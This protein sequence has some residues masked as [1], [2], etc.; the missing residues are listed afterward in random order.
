M[1]HAF[2]ST[3]VVPGGSLP[4]TASPGLLHL[5][6]QA[7]AF[8]QGLDP[9][10]PAVAQRLRDLALRL[11]EDRFHL[12]VLGQ[13]KRGKSTL[14]NALLGEPLLPSAVVPLTSIPTFIHAGV[15]LE[16]KIS[17]QDENRAETYACDRAE[18]MSNYLAR[19]VAEE[20]NPKNHLG[21]S[22]VE[23]FHPAPILQRGVVLIDT[24]GIGSTFR[25]NTE[26]TLNFLPQCDA[27]LFVVSADPPVT[28]VE[29]EFLGQVRDKVARLFF[30]LNKVD[31]LSLEER[32]Q[33]ADF[34]KR[35]LREQLG[36][37][38]DVILFCVSARQGLEAAGRE[39]STLWRQSG[40][41]ELND[42]LLDFLVEG[43]SSALNEAVARKAAD[44]VGEVAMRVDL[45]LRALEMPLTELAERR[46][47]FEEKLA[48][49]RDQ[50]QMAGDLLA[51]D[52]KRMQQFLESKAAE[53]RQRAT[54][55]L[56]QVV[57]D[58]LSKTMAGDFHQ[59]AQDALDNQV[60][61]FFERELG[62]LIRDVDQRLTQVLRPH[63]ARAT[64]LIASVRKTAAE[65]FEVPYHAPESE[66]ALEIKRQPY[67]VTARWL[68]S[69]S[70]I[71]PLPIERWLPAGTRRARARKRLLG[72]IRD[73]VMHNV[74][75]I[76]WATLQNLDQSFRRFGSALAER[77]DD[78]L[79]ATHGAIEAAAI[80]RQETAERATEEGAKLRT[81]AVEIQ[82]ILAA[83]EQGG[84]RGEGAR[85][86]TG[87]A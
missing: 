37:P 27:A 64:E 46:R 84:R 2:A 16:T 1:K 18:E 81:A 19:F 28:E 78:T 63:Q 32:K 40:L 83:L 71:P 26:A 65:L 52:R 42:F 43:K 4:T 14:L 38:E 59:P 44:M 9:E 66:G 61:P 48:E 15:R 51:G 60:P 30:V 39:D 13:F 24:P 29:L 33:A 8:V 5:L 74:E 22:Q 36:F 21:V 47:I 34:F 11:Q 6:D 57:N 79:A 72:Q 31:Y 56:E 67:W 25:H 17:F 87:Q 45:A 82:R 49:I 3:N 69:I 58:A 86:T 73:L 70:P 77:L 75:N 41:A 53:L 12:A 35:V 10:M 54:T 50:Q 68:A 23:V 76:R 20:H 7:T 55:T 62:A 80:R 85:P